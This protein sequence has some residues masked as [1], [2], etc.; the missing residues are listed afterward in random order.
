METM[1]LVCAVVGGTLVVCQF[2]MI[3]VGF[4]GHDADM[5]SGD[6]HVGDFHVGHAGGGEAHAGETHGGDSHAD[7]AQHAAQHGSSAS[8]GGRIAPS[9]RG[10]AP[11]HGAAD[12]FVRVLSFRTVVA[13]IALFGVT[14]KAARAAGFDEVTT[15]AIAVGSGIAAMYA[16]HGLM[17]GLKSLDT[18]RTM[19]IERAIGQAGTVYLS[20]PAHR[21]GMGKIQLTLQNRLD[22]LEAVTAGEG[23]PGGAK[24][25]VVGIVGPSTVEVEALT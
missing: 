4:A 8:R 13:A 22:E 3:L 6:V 1:F 11:S 10:P 16:V 19:R 12:W 17:R 20:I 14:G 23:L 24:V 18:D 9:A 21:T 5:H 25:K 2:L 15:L 7:Q